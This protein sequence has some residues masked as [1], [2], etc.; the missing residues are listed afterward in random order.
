MG[1]PG[2]FQTCTM[3]TTGGYAAL[4]AF[5]ERAVSAIILYVL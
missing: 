3:G 4:R 1:L 5:F 2:E